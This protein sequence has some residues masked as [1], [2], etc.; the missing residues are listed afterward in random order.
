MIGNFIRVEVKYVH[1]DAGSLWWRVQIRC[2]WIIQVLDTDPCGFD[3]ISADIPTNASMQWLMNVCYI[4]VRRCDQDSS[5]QVFAF[6][7][8]CG[9][10]TV[11]KYTARV[12]CCRHIRNFDVWPWYRLFRRSRRSFW[13]GC[14]R[15]RCRW[16]RPRCR[17][18]SRCLGLGCRWWGTLQYICWCKIFCGPDISFEQSSMTGREWV[19]MMQYMLR[20][21]YSTWGIV[22]ACVKTLQIPSKYKIFGV[23][24]LSTGSSRMRYEIWSLFV[25][26]VTR[27][28]SNRRQ[29]WR[30][31]VNGYCTKKRS[32]TSHIYTN[33][34]LSLFA[35]A[36]PSP[37]TWGRI[38]FAGSES[39]SC[40]RHCITD[41]EGIHMSSLQVAAF[42]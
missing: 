14:R 41:S 18:Q 2:T 30:M 15:L 11:H 6:F 21:T 40:N 16:L 8:D 9:I 5:D 13:R 29:W 1:L 36:R 37:K 3:L 19:E 33:T 38:E 28:S 23:C 4:S 35:R 20:Y 25:E 27:F 26:I 10:V 32:T 7:V 24:I 17:L 22:S 12:K 42:R 31:N 34:F 39:F